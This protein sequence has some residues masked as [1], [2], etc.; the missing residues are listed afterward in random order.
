MGK[1]AKHEIWSWIL[2]WG[3][4]WHKINAS[5]L[6]FARSFQGHPTWPYLERSIMCPNTAKYG[7]IRQIRYLGCV[8]GHAKHGQVGCPWKGLAKCSALWS[9]FENMIANV[10]WI[11]VAFESQSKARSVFLLDKVAHQVDKI[12][13]EVYVSC[14]IQIYLAMSRLFLTYFWWIPTLISC[15]DNQI[16]ET[17]CI[18]SRLSAALDRAISRVGGDFPES[19]QEREED[20]ST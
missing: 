16:W 8:F 4:Y 3:S 19:R 6:H 5:E 17:W 12:V 9:C 1:S 18:Y 11:S 2:T 13:D 10:F 14:E 7:Q 15:S 20:V